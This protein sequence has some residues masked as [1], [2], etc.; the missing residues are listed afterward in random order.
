MISSSLLRWGMPLLVATRQ[1]WKPFHRPFGA[2]GFM[3][4]LK[5]FGRVLLVSSAPSGGV[6]PTAP[7]RKS[8]L[9][10]AEYKVA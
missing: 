7:L 3:D 2:E 5:P 1:L 6:G 9:P 8:I 10:D 4:S